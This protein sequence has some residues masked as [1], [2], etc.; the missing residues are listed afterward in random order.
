MSTADVKVN[1]VATGAGVPKHA[2]LA[3]IL[4]ILVS[5]VIALAVSSCSPMASP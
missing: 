3:Q 5:G 4:S 2:K 1:V